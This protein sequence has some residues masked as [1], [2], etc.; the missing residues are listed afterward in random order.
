MLSW[1]LH[2]WLHH[3]SLAQRLVEV[4][5]N[6]HVTRFLILFFPSSSVIDSVINI[7]LV[8]TEPKN[9]LQIMIKIIKSSEHAFPTLLPRQSVPGIRHCWPSWRHRLVEDE[10]LPALFSDCRALRLQLC[11]L[12]FIGIIHLLLKS[13]RLLL[14]RDIVICV[15]LCKCLF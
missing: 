15:C 2:N 8:S 9:Y 11:H 10:K 12:R 13:A 7:V 1:A 4:I 6:D 14:N 5:W 3:L